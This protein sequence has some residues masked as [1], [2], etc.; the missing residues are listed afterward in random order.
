MQN[1]LATFTHEFFHNYIIEL[2]RNYITSLHS[3]IFSSVPGPLT[4]INLFG[5]NVK[6]IFF[7]VSTTGNNRSVF[8]ILT[9]NNKF[10]FG[11]FTDEST[12]IKSKELIEE[13][14]NNVKKFINFK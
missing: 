10:N 7:F 14:I 2:T 4:E 8:T 11:C 12:G 13:F 5:Y 1:I 9:Y 3:G 6:D